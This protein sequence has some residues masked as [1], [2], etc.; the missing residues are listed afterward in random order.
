MKSMQTEI[1]FLSECNH[2]NI[3]KMK[4]WFEENGF[5]HC[6]YDLCQEGSLEELYTKTRGSQKMKA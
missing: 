6:V 1:E 3:I 4:E 2:H 5:L